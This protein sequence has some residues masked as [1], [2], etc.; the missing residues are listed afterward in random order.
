M[1][2]CKN[3][4]DK[5]EPIH[6]N[7]KFCSKDEC[8]KVWI[9]TA[10]AKQWVK[11]KR[12]R[13]EKLETVQDLMKKAQRV[14]NTWIRK[15]DK[16]KPCVSCGKADTGKRDAS[17]YYSSGNHKAVTFNEDNVHASCV[18][19]NQYLAG[20]LLNYQIGLTER[21]GADRVFKLNEQ[22]HKTAKYSREELKDIIKK[23]K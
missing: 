23:Y 2:R 15:R 10:K 13:K 18:Y 5:F 20:N 7:A 21:I 16:G 12:E 6:F 14:F 8:R 19:C 3:C 1:P 11:E 4:K 22:A 17:H 9:E